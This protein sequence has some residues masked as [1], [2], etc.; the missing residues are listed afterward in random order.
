M[1]HARR[2]QHPVHDGEPKLH[3]KGGCKQQM[4]HAK[5]NEVRP[6]MASTNKT[7]QGKIVL[8]LKNSKDLTEEA[9]KKRK[10]QKGGNRGDHS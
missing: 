4:T 1:M 5:D 7:H 3:E 2:E 6:I 8:S 9:K 10:S